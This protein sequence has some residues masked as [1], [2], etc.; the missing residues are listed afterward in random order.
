VGITSPAGG[1]TV[2]GTV[3]VTA[4]ASDDVGVLGVQFKLDGVNLVAEDTTAPY[5]VSWNTTTTTN[6]SHTLTAVARDVLN[7]TT[8]APIDVTISNTVLPPVPISF[9]QQTGRV[10]AGGVGSLNAS[11]ATPPTAGNAVIVYAWSY[12][13]DATLD[14]PANGVTDNRG[15]TYQLAT[16][17]ALASNARAAIYYATNIA[18]GAGTFTLTVNP[19]GSNGPITVNAMEYT[20][21]AA[22]GALDKVATASG[23]GASVSTGSITTSSPNELLVGV[24][25][26][27]PDA[28]SVVW[29]EQAGWTQRVEETDNWTFQAGHGVSREV[30]TAG[31][32]AHTWS[33]SPGGPWTAAIVSFKGQPPAQLWHASYGTPVM[34]AS[35][36]RPVDRVSMLLKVS[37]PP[38]PT[39]ALERPA[40]VGPTR[41]RVRARLKR[42]RRLR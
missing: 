37:W 2:S 36:L 4:N 35:D 28:A 9:V 7:Q 40:R 15:N 42:A 16:K 10:H 25:A 6:G 26:A 12:N 24:A 23:T 27:N 39:A 3:N 32:Y 14:F 8:S 22:V 17:T 33:L 20:G 30:T 34:A 31:A 18:S 11:F 21:I 29:A 1:A 41:V 13:G 38:E 19:S 5:A